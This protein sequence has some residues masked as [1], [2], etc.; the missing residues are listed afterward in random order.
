V[1]EDRLLVR[2]MAQARQVGGRLQEVAHPPR[3]VRSAA[4]LPA[5]A[6]S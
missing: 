1:V 5:V 4:L 6:G 3:Q 2:A